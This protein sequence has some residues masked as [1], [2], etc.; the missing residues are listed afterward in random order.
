MSPLFPKTTI[1]TI[2]GFKIA[3]N[4]H[5]F[6]AVHTQIEAAGSTPCEIV[7]KLGF[8]ISQGVES[9][10]SICVCTSKN[11]CTLWAI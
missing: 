11:V 1:V 6:L 10:A 2:L 9:A 4:V 8:K 7:I 3:H 5:T